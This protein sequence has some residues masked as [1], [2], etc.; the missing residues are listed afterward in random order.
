MVSF[1]IS[2]ALISKWNYK[3]L[4]LSSENSVRATYVDLDSGSCI[5][6]VGVRSVRHYLLNN[7]WCKCSLLGETHIGSEGAVWNPL[8]GCAGSS[9]LQ[10]AVNL[11]EGQTLGL[12]DE[13]VGVDE[14]S[15]AEGTP[16]EEDTGF[17]ISFALTISDQVWGDDSD[18]AVPEPVGSSGKTDTTGSDGERE[19]FT[20]EDPGACHE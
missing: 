1:H 5:S 15:C 9:L 10:H 4:S 11:L 3:D 20:D 16:E 13:K 14:A 18:D 17:E 8:G 7:L 12:R 2:Q 6:L 19:D